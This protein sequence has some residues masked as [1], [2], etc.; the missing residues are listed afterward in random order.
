MKHREEFT[1]YLREM[2]AVLEEQQN[3]RIQEA[4]SSMEELE[5]HLTKQVKQT[6][7]EYINRS[8][9][10]SF[11]PREQSHLG[12]SVSLQELSTSSHATVVQ[13]YCCTGSVVYCCTLPLYY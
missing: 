9:E 13:L 8:Y 6:C 2:D 12:D 11:K 4:E 3:E 10:T 5:E 1:K 7:A